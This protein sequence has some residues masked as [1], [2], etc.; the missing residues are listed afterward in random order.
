MARKVA[1][2]QLGPG[3]KIG[4]H[5]RTTSWNPAVDTL[6]AQKRT[7]L[8]GDTGL[9]AA[10]DPRGEDVDPLKELV[11]PAI[12]AVPL[13]RRRTVVQLQSQGLT[14]AQ[15]S[16]LLGMVPDRIHRDRYAAVSELR[17][18]LG[19]LIRDGHRKKTRRAKKDR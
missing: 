6:R 7:D 9:V 2:A 19:T 14:D 10:P 4:A 16:E 12:E 3:V 8:M 5:P 15:I 1:A 13:S 18:E 17:S 11:R